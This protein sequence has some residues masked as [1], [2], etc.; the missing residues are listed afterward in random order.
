VAEEEEEKVAASWD[1]MIAT[2]TTHMATMTM[3]M[4][5]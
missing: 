3:T 1:A 2:S 4:T 5:T